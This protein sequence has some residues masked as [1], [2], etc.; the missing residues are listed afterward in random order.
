MKIAI[1]GSLDFTYEIEKIAGR[2]R[3]LGF[4][5]TIPISSE[6]ILRGEFSLEDIKSKK[7]TGKFSDYAIKY[8]F[9]PGLLEGYR[10][11]RRD[12][13][14]QLRQKGDQKLYRR[15]F[16]PGNGIRPRF[17]K[18]NFSFERDSGNDLHRRDQSNA[19]GR[20]KRELVKNYLLTW[21][22]KR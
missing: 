13:C 6:R 20:H 17:G 15:E 5:V 8:D 10:R 12:T 21:Q 3:N 18:E 16:I 9:D 4:E 2:L 19:A 7:E 22:R 1:C 14:C 11:V